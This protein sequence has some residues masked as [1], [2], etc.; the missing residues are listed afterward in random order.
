MLQKTSIVIPCDST[1]VFS[2]Y[3]FQIYQRK[4][5]YSGSFGKCSLRET[6]PNNVLYKKKK[7][8]CY[9]LRTTNIKLLPDTTYFHYHLN[10]ILLLKKRLYPRGRVLMGPTNYFIKRKKLLK[11]FVKIL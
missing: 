3:I 5:G 4:Y 1:G 2:A 11:S 7:V 9:V 10:N 8:R 6:R